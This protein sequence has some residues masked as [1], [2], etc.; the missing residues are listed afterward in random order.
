[1]MEIENAARGIFADTRAAKEGD[2]F[3]V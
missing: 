3:V 1:M 2:E